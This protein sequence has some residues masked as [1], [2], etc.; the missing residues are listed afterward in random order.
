MKGFLVFL[1][2]LISLPL[3]HAHEVRPAYME[4]EQ[5]SATDLNLRLRQPIVALSENRMAGLDLRPGFPTTCE[6]SPDGVPRRM[7][8]YLTQYFTV[9][10]PDGLKGSRIQ[11]D[12][13]RRSLTDVYV[14]LS[15]S[16]GTTQSLLLNAQRPDFVWGGDRD[17]PTIAFLEIGLHHM[18]GGLDHVLFVI[19][20]LL[21]VPRFV[22]LLAVATTFTIAHS[23]TLA[24]SVTGLV[25]LPSAPV[26]AGIAL[27]VLYLAYELSRPAARRSP[28]AI[29][30]PELIAFG[31]GLLHGFGFAGALSETGMPTDQLLPALFFFNLGVEAGQIFV[32]GLVLAGLALVSRLWT[33]F[34]HRLRAGL[35][36][37]LTVGAAYF[38][39]GAL[40]GLIFPL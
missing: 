22:R 13:L 1:A 17:R 27:S 39:A 10:C 8:A 34:R 28:V 18:L 16:E 29:R 4:L 37:V 32:I 35:S 3:G 9:S 24:L 2:C 23:L 36:A 6:V 26:E 15:D 40:S 7:E 38:F 14:V 19:G 5:T 30:H 20:L 11:V 33:G 31:F 25:Y 21:L 12:G